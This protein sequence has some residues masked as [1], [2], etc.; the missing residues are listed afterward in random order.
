MEFFKV[1]FLR[2]LSWVLGV[3]PVVQGVWSQVT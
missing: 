3:K 2:L 1:K